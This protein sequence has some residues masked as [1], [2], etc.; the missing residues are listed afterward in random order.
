MTI[1]FVCDEALQSIPSPE[2]PA[3]HSHW[4]VTALQNPLPSHDVVQDLVEPLNSRPIEG[5][6][7][8]GLKQ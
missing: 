7:F 4:P 8:D 1:R 3:L 6:G 5:I 2:K